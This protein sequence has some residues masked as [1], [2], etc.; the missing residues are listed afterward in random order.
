MVETAEPSIKKKT[1][2][3]TELAKVWNV[4]V[5]NDPINTMSYVAYVFEKV[6]QLTKEVAHKRMLEVH[7]AGKSVVYSG[8]KEKAEYYV[9]QLQSYQLNATLEQSE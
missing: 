2:P 7:N 9:H 3:R 1:K 8:D 5:W 6:L 4:L